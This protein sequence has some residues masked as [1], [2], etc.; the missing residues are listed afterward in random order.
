MI[1]Q[2]YP[3]HTAR[4]SHW[5]GNF[6]QK[7]PFWLN[8]C[9]LLLQALVTSHPMLVQ[10]KSFAE[11]S[12]EEEKNI[13]R[14]QTASWQSSFKHPPRSHAT[15]M[16]HDMSGST[17]IVHPLVK[18]R[19]EQRI[20]TMCWHNWLYLKCC[21][22]V[23]CWYLPTNSWHHH[24]TNSPIIAPIGVGND[25]T[26]SVACAPLPNYTWLQTIAIPAI[27]WL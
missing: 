26:V 22:D 25:W 21:G 16:T 24:N 15:K 4:I 8:C 1:R 6:T 14:L 20:E 23:N 27:L 3:W 11:I 19:E 13:L 17:V 18:G 7:F 5:T 2:D 10:L 9:H 12:L